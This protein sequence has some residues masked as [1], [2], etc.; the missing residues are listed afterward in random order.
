MFFEDIVNRICWWNRHGIWEK[1]KSRW[2]RFWA[3]A[4]RVEVPLV[5]MKKLEVGQ[6]GEEQGIRCQQAE[7]EISVRD[8]KHWI[9]NWMYRS[10]VLEGGGL[11][12]R[13]KFHHGIFLKLCRLTGLERT[14]K[15]CNLTLVSSICP[16]FPEMHPLNYQFSCLNLTNRWTSII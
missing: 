8:V 3:W 11:G 15:V 12:W 5:K 13:Y 4:S 2:L 10:E 1:E 14:T 6:A 9:D 7:F 16:A